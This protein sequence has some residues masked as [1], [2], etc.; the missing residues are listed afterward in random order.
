[1]TPAMN[2]AT[3]I[4][5]NH[6]IP[7]YWAPL[8]AEDVQ[9]R[10]CRRSIELNG[11]RVS[12]GSPQ[13]K[14]MQRY[15]FWCLLWLQLV[16]LVDAKIKV[17]GGRTMS[18]EQLQVRADS[19]PEDVWVAWLAPLVGLALGMGIP[20]CVLCYTAPRRYNY[21][22]ATAIPALSVSNFFKHVGKARPCVVLFHAMS[23]TDCQ[24]FRFDFETIYEE[25]YAKC[26]KEGLKPPRFFSVDYEAEI[27]LGEHFNVILKGG[28]SMMWFAAGSKEPVFYSG[29]GMD[30][31]YGWLVYWVMQRVIK[32][33]GS[34]ARLVG[35]ERLI[36]ELYH[37]YDGYDCSQAETRGLDNAVE[38]KNWL[39]RKMRGPEASVYGEVLPEGVQAVLDTIEAEMPLSSSDVF[40]DLGSG[41][42]KVCVQV[43]LMTPCKKACGIELSETRH[44]HALR[45]LAEAKELSTNPQR[46]KEKEIEF[47]RDMVEA[48]NT[49]RLVLE[50]GDIMD[51]TYKDGTH[52]FAASTTWPD[53]LMS[54][55]TKNLSTGLP[56]IKTFS[57]LREPEDVDLNLHPHVYLWKKIKVDVS[58][59]DSAEMHIFRF[60][61]NGAEKGS[62]GKKTK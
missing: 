4:I 11:F 19:V 9:L 18:K 46:R 17:G 56:K 33:G 31:N 44:K 40:Y 45:A 48:E 60:D 23:D 39:V 10:H 49:G 14:R 51:L 47:L 21:G 35:V 20:C 27:E 52:I 32:A 43:S 3:R 15:V 61:G 6:A 2:M 28:P 29:G 50:Q 59:T 5:L 30:G 13:Q 22:P 55:I 1:M 37:W 25:T 7:I 8:R 36:Q 26:K 62:E 53:K 34:G 41:T 24:D 42:G 54:V 16:A 12:Q 57:T 58:W 38:D